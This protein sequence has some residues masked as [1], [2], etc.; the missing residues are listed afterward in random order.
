MKARERPPRAKQR[1]LERVVGVVHGA[2]HAV[3]MGM[4]LRA[5]ALHERP[6]RALV[7]TARLAQPDVF[8]V[9]A[10]RH[11]EHLDRHASAN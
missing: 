10:N 9:Q 2:E 4:E 7:V 6:K 3:A 5:L 8:D 11:S 1:L